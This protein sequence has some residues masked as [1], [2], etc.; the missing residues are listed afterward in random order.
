MF[1]QDQNH[2]AF[3]DAYYSKVFPIYDVTRKYFLFGRDSLLDEIVKLQPSTVI[4]VGCGTGRN[5]AKLKQRLTKTQFGAIEPCASMRE[6]AMEKYPWLTITPSLAEKA[7]LD[8]LLPEKPDIIFLSYALSMIQNREQVLENCV[9]A[10]AQKGRVYVVDFGNLQGLGRIG[11]KAFTRWLHAFHVHPE[12]LETVFAK[13]ES[14]VNGPLCYWKRGM[15][16]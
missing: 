13:A 3:L 6:Y 7:Q 15:F 12:R 8:R 4:E 5:L 16:L 2:I 11:Q 1:E 9:C 14:I 10:L